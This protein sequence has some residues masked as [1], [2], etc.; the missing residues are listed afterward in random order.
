MAKKPK[1]KRK[2][3]VATKSGKSGKRRASRVTSKMK[4]TA[5]KVLAGAAAGAVRAA[6]PPLEK[7]EA[8]GGE[9][10]GSK[11]RKR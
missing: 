11:G 10:S 1:P 7:A 6:M 9:G 5:M 2:G 3:S 4:E 8:A